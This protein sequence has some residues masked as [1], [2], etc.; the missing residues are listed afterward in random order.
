[1]RSDG[2][3]L[4]SPFADSAAASSVPYVAKTLWGSMEG[5]RAIMDTSSPVADSSWTGDPCRRISSPAHPPAFFTLPTESGGTICMHAYNEPRNE[6]EAPDCSR[7]RVFPLPWRW[8]GEGRWE[9]AGR[10]KVKEQS[11]DVLPGVEGE[12]LPSVT[13][14]ERGCH[15]KTLQLP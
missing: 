11:H 1:M 10:K 13:Q 12:L 9:M 7:A 5:T 3:P 6:K 14:K 15:T 4:F 8:E 2:T